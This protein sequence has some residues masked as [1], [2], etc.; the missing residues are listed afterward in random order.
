M[1]PVLMFKDVSV[2]FGSLDV[3]RG[4]SF[5]VNPEDVVGIFGRSGAGKTTIIR[6]AAGLMDPTSGTVE[7][8][9]RRVGYVFQEPRVLPWKT[10]LDNIVIPLLALGAGRNEAV[11]RARGWLVDMGL[12]GFEDYYPSRLSGGMVQRVSLARAF[13][14]EPDVLFLDEPFGALDL[15]IKDTM[16]DLLRKSLEARPVTVLYVSHVPEDVVRIATRIFVIDADGGLGEAP[17]MDHRDMA[18]MLR[19]TFGARQE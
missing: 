14:V 12:E 9:Y 13:A 2:S 17:V 18:E 19:K 11:D 5:A 6:M 7:R 15:R 1:T 3:V 16:F 8:S 4:V 10:T